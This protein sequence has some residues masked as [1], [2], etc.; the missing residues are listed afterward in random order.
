M[1]HGEDVLVHIIRDIFVGLGFKVV[2]PH[3]VGHPA[4]VVFPGT[5]LPEDPVIGQLLAIGRI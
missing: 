2:D 4:L 5:E 3:I 1:P